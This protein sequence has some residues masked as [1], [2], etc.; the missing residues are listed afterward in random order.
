[1]YHFVTRD[2]ISDGVY[3]A[4]ERIS[5][6][7]ALRTYMINNAKLSFEEAIKGSLE[8]GK[9]ADLVVIS[10]DFLTVPDKEIERM[11]AL[12]TMVGGRFV[13]TTPEFD[14]AK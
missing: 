6:E 14:G 4:H 3:G 7:Q 5:R 13:Y 8:T 10:G 1:M 2:T 11:R 9:L 12:A